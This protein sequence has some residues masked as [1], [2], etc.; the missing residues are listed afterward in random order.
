[1]S[2]IYHADHR[3]HHIHWTTSNRKDN[4][5]ILGWNFK[6]SIATPTSR[7]FP[8]VPCGIRVKPTI[9]ECTLTFKKSLERH[10]WKGVEPRGK[11]ERQAD[12]S[13]NQREACNLSWG[14]S[15][16]AATLC[17]CCCFCS[18]SLPSSIFV[19]DVKLRLKPYTNKKKNKIKKI[20]SYPPNLDFPFPI[21][22]NT[23]T[24]TNHCC[25]PISLHKHSHNYS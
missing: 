17:W 8:W 3:Q 12:F 23:P 11:L 14:A 25:S 15:P 22:I 9:E 6:S 2:W 1:M 16:C 5:I 24:T 18:L 7:G 4:L 21:F 20:K 13:H 19:S 10:V